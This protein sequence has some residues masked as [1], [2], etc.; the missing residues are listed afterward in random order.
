MVLL[1]LLFV[2]ILNLKFEVHR[3]YIKILL[4]LFWVESQISVISFFIFFQASFV[5]FALKVLFLI[6]LDKLNAGFMNVSIV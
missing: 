5:V 1:Y 6:N 4:F 2:F 3:C